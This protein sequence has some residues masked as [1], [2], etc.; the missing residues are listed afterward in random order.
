MRLA[1]HRL[2]VSVDAVVAVELLATTLAEKRMATV[3]P[4]M[5]LFSNNMNYLSNP[6]LT[7]AGPDG[8]R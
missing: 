2:L 6:P 4:T 3:L 7:P 1:T 8:S 5:I